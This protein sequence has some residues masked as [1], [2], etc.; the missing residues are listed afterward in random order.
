MVSDR[1]YT[2]FDVIKIINLKMERL[3]DWLKRGYI[4]PTYQEPVGRGMKNYFD[5]VQLYVIQAFKY[6]VENGITREVAAEWTKDIHKSVQLD[7][8][9]A[10]SRQDQSKANLEHL[11]KL[12]TFIVIYKGRSK[13]GDA[14]ATVVI[15]D[16]TE[17]IN[18]NAAMQADA[19][20]IINFSN[21][22]KQVDARLEE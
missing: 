17:K 14:D 13:F 10:K 4:Q 11:R 22:V 5:L 9:A 15:K 3:Q 18:L 1:F 8:N 12:P 7:L 6:L 2:T 16:N 21:I 20:H 19:V